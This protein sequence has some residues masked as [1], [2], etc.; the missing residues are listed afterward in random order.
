MEAEILALAKNFLPGEIADS[1]LTV[2]EKLCA[3]AL[4]MFRRQLRVSEEECRDTLVT[5]SAMYAAGE[6]LLLGQA[7][8]FSACRVGSVS[9]SGGMDSAARG[10]ALQERARMLMGE[11][12]ADEGFCF[13]GVR[14]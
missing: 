5:A 10:S 6:A 12:I 8:S 7:E 1:A 2:L 11:L 4:E 14:A 9:L 3:T 13:K